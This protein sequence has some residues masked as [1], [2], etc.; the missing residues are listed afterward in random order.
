[1][2][3]NSSAGVA[4]KQNYLGTY[5]SDMDAATAYDLA[6]MKL[7]GSYALTNFR[8]PGHDSHLAGL[9]RQPTEE[10]LSPDEGAGLWDDDDNFCSETDDGNAQAPSVFYTS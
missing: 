9:A 4:G 5:S 1:M 7:F 6:A 3:L 2:N 8:L 10:N